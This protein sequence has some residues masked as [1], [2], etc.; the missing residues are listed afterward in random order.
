MISVGSEADMS[1]S[2]KCSFPS[3]PTATT[4]HRFVNIGFERNQYMIRIKK[5][6]LLSND[7]STIVQIAVTKQLLPKKK[8]SA[9]LMDRPT[10]RKE[11]LN[12]S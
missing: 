7:A 6:R 1:F 11:E 4:H 9:K 2:L 5:P 8:G 3:V 12:E 10:I